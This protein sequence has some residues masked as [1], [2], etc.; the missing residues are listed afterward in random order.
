MMPFERVGIVE[1]LGAMGALNG[2]HSLY[3]RSAL[4]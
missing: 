4:S 1:V 3:T 2:H